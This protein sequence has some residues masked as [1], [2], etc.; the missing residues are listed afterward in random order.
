ML[1]FSYATLGKELAAQQRSVLVDKLQQASHLIGNVRDSAAL[2]ANAY[3]LVE[4]VKGQSE[5][6]MAVASIDSGEA[7]VAFSREAVESLRRLRQDTWG[8]NAYLE[9]KTAE[10]GLRCCRS[11]APAARWMAAPRRCRGV[12]ASR[13]AW[14]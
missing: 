4:L 1:G 5:L 11:Q 2:K 9:W 13:P 10:G 12:R 6:H 3:R 8:T 14:P 7:H